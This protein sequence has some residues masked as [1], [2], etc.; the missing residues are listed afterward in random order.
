MKFVKPKKIPEANIQAEIYH[1]CRNNNI[2]V[3]LEY[4]YKHCRFDIVIINDNDDIVLYIETKSHKKPNIK[5]KSYNTKQILKYSHYIGKENIA[6]CTHC[7]QLQL[8]KE[9]ILLRLNDP[10]CVI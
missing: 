6:I 3:C 1:F 7:K 5:N 9:K 10:H 2:R 8:T 4:S